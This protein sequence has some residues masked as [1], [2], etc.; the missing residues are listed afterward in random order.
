MLHDVDGAQLKQA[1]MLPDQDALQLEQ[2]LLNR[3]Q[4]PVCLEPSVDVCRTLNLAQFVANSTR[5]RFPKPARPEVSV[6]RN[7][8]DQEALKKCGLRSGLQ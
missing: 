3:L 7:H 8:Y 1:F 6:F 5:T 2:E 4:L